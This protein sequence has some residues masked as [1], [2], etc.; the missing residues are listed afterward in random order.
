MNLVFIIWQHDDCGYFEW[1]DLE[2]PAYKKQVFMRLKVKNQRYEETM[3]ISSNMEL[4]MSQKVK[5]AE[6]K[7]KE[8][9]AKYAKTLEEYES[10]HDKMERKLDHFQRKETF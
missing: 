10:L 3:K 7:L 2:I 1:L 4:R 5:L 8:N 9:H 6:I